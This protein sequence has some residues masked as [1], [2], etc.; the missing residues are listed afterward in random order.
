MRHGSTQLMIF[1]ALSEFV[2]QRRITPSRDPD[3]KNV[4]VCVEGG[5]GGN[6]LK[7]QYS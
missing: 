1:M 2:D 4:S 7:L 5:G 3:A 6:W